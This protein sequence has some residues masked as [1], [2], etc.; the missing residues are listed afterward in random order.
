MLTANSF[1]NFGF[2]V[3]LASLLLI[4]TGF[5]LGSFR[6]E[7]G[8]QVAGL[9]FAVGLGLIPLVVSMVIPALV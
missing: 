2:I 7:E 3:S 5:L 8:E 6:A 4:T 9:P 1:A